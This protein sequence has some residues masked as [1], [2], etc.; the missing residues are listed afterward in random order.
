MARD[1]E[2]RFQD[3]PAV[4]LRELDLDHIELDELDATGRPKQQARRWISGLLWTVILVVALVFPYTDFYQVQGHD[5]GWFFA[6]CAIAIV[7]GIGVGRWLWAWLLDVAAKIDRYEDWSEPLPEPTRFSPKVLRWLTLLAALV[8]GVLVVVVIPEDSLAGPGS[9]SG[10]AFL[11]AILAIVVGVL[12]GRWLLMQTVVREVLETDRQPI[13]LP[14]WFKWITLCV[15]L[16]AGMATLFVPKL[17]GSDA[18]DLAFAFGGVALGVGVFGAIW[19]SR[20][21]EELQTKMEEEAKKQR[22]HSVL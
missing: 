2:K 6:L 16:C 13:R 4:K 5:T 20:R 15:L 3:L 19:L 1:M 14:K 18:R 8:G 22:R 17:A 11:A 12:A 9:M 10:K 7:A 21:F